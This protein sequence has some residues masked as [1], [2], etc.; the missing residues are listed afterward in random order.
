MYLNGKRSSWNARDQEFD[1]SV[2]SY[3]FF[4]IWTKMITMDI[5][6]LQEEQLSATGEKI[7]RTQSISKL[8]LQQCK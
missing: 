3:A 1:P 8:P 7:E 4:K 5:L 2:L 6:P